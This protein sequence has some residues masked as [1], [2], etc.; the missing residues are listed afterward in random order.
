M[1][2]KDP[3]PM[4]VYRKC[5]PKEPWGSYLNGDLMSPGLSLESF[6][7]YLMSQFNY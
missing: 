6:S 2:G 1:F 7:L 4:S 3:R 5:V